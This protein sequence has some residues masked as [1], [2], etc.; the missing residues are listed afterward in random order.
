[1]Q[2]SDLISGPYKLSRQPLLVTLSDQE[3]A[4]T[5]EFV[6]EMREDKVKH[7]VKDRMFDIKNTSEGINIIGHLGEQAVAKVLGIP[8]D[9]TVLTGGDA[10]HDLTLNGTT[11]QVKTS[12]LP[13]LIFNAKHLFKSDVAVLVQYIGADNRT[14]HEDPRFQ[15]WGWVDQEEFFKSYYNE[16]FGYGRRLV[17]DAVCLHSLDSLTETTE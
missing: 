3:V 13:K 4:K 10:G 1:M 12:I 8:V 9:T 2:T 5:L 7:N 17:F 14:A 6:A 16:D 11:I 15:I